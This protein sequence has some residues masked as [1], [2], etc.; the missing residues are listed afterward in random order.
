MFLLIITNLTTAQNE[1]DSSKINI[2][3]DTVKSK[4]INLKP[5]QG[6]EDALDTTTFKVNEI[7]FIGYP[8]LF[9]TPETQLAF[10]IGGMV[11]FRTALQPA[12]KPSKITVG[13]YYTTNSQYLISIKPRIYFPGIKRTYLESDF[14]YSYDVLKF[15]GLGNSTAES[16]TIDYKSS[17]FGIY[18]ETQ[19]R[20]F[21]FK[22]LQIGFVYDYLKMSM[23][24]KMNNPNLNDSTI[25]GTD[26][27][28]VGGLG[29]SWSFDYRDNISY[30]SQ[31]GLYKLTAI[32]YGRS[33]GGEFTY[34]RY[35]F[36]FRQYVAPIL[37]HILAFQLYTDLNAG[38]SPFF[39]MPALG[40]SNRMRGFFEGRYRDKNYITGQ[41]EY[42]KIIFWRIGVA[43]FYSAGDVFSNFSN[44]KFSQVKQAY[45]FGL[46]FVFDEKEK[47]NLRA[48]FGISKEGTG[49]Y[50]SMDEAF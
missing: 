16:D 20:G 2:N 1:P 34:N 48:D 46:R 23:E 41:I 27:G 7:K 11:Y 17:T 42:R 30:P 26:G 29:L 6:I 32:F 5:N 8:Y 18:V 21:L 50:F 43:A 40:G 33:F 12:Q 9:Y 19:Q 49:V 36:D 35:R 24:D 4:T 13:G 25:K 15:Y 22:P 38:E 28:K 31:G 45:G 37:D 39:S 44:L 10:G 14:Y 47:I 3:K